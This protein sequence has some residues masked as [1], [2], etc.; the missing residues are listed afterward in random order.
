M[1]DES[2]LRAPVAVPKIAGLSALKGLV[3][4]CATLAFAGLYGYFIVKISTATG[5]P[6]KIDS[7]LLSGAAALA[8]VL[9]SAF[10]LEVGTTTAPGATN[11]RLARALKAATGKKR[12]LLRLHKALSLDAS[13][14]NCASWPKTLGIWVYAIVAAAVAVTYA[15]NPNQTP[16]MIKALA[17]AFAGYVLALITAAYKEDEATASDT[18]GEAGLSAN[19][20][21]A[22]K[23]G[24]QEPAPVS[25]N[26]HGAAKS[27]SLKPAASVNGNGAA[28][29]AHAGSVWWAHAP[30]PSGEP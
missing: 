20:G 22:V 10:A 17:V 30:R 24:P 6:P 1:A 5:A 2:N 3:V 27:A 25:A 14:S 29:R 11:K 18:A 21:Q 8:G 12:W 4:Y 26:G 13:S 23:P 28:S 19:G 7:V 9:G 16:A 15:L